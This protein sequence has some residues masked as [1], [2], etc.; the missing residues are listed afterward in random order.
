V[1]CKEGQGADDPTLVFTPV[2]KGGM[3][4]FA[5]IFNAVTRKNFQALSLK[6]KGRTTRNSSAHLAGAG[7]KIRE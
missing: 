3:G 7:K 4:A 5:K 6:Q 2:S 1:K